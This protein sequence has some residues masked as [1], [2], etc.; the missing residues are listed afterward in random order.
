[1]RAYALAGA[2]ALLRRQA[3]LAEFPQQVPIIEINS[4]VK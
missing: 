4:L 3:V 2:Q 1:M